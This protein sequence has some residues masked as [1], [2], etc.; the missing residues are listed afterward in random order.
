MPKRSTNF[1]KRKSG[2]RGSKKPPFGK[3][4]DDKK[5]PPFGDKKAD[6]KDDDGEKI[7]G[8]TNQVIT[9]VSMKD[10][11]EGFDNPRSKAMKNFLAKEG[12]KGTGRVVGMSIELP[13][14]V[15][16][17]TK[18]SEWCDDAGS[19][20]FRGDSETDAI[21]QFKRNVRRAELNEAANYKLYHDS[22]TSAVNTAL[23]YAE[24]LGYKTDPEEAADKIG[25]GPK[26]P[27]VGKT[28][29]IRLRVYKNGNLEK[30]KRLTMAIYGMEGGKYEL[31]CYVA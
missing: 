17:Y 23:K 31:T 22:Y 13:D 21:K 27:S 7:G 25:L 24:S 29:T 26:K 30:N 12:P 16:I 4:D 28:N 14:G 5:K 18:S 3:K 8:G 6:K 11:S 19:G 2:E 9:D 1:A 15:F 20:T 10:L